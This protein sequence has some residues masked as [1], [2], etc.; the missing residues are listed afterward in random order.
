[1]W[2][3]R[4]RPAPM[5][6][7]RRA[8]RTCIVQS[9][10]APPTVRTSKSR[11]GNDAR[12]NAHSGV[13]RIARL[14]SHGGHGGVRAVVDRLVGAGAGRQGP[15]ILHA[16]ARSKRTIAARLCD[17]RRPPALA[18]GGRRCRSAFL[19]YAIRLRG[20][21]LARPPRRRSDGVDPR[22]V[23]ARQQ[24]PHPLR[25]LDT[26]YAGRALAG[27]APRTDAFG[28]TPSD[29]A[30]DRDRACAGQGRCAVALSRTRALWWQHRGRPRRVV[31]LF[32]QGTA[33]PFARR[34]G[35]SC[36]FAAIARITATRSLSRCRARG[37]VLDRYAATGAVP[38]EEITLAKAEPVPSARYPMPLLAPHAADEA[39]AATPDN[40]ELRLT[41]DAELQKNLEDLA[42]ERGR[43][44]AARLG[45]DISLALIVVDNATGEVLAHVGSPAYFD[46]RR[47]GQV[48]MTRALRS[49]G[50]TLKPFIYGLGFEDGLIHP[51][52]LI[53]DRPVSYGAYTPQNFDFTFQG[54][55]TIRQALQFSLNV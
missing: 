33:P 49:P 24:R 38:A 36:G 25:R 41:I 28:K 47:A 5:C 17:E 48:D 6:A 42:R 46:E 31:R 20:Q 7:R 29:L 9:A 55:V 37:G 35:A 26:D 27:A 3:V 44:L 4:L 19:R 53:E 8:S 10:S 34:S 54:T 2:C 16:R 15:R 50:S 30:R 51:E 32:R 23:P 1:M 39:V 18:G 13:G 14:R 40:H 22:G 11:S 43:T 12:Q 52:T 45:P 21:A